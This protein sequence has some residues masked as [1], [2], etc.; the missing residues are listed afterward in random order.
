MAYMILNETF[1]VSQSDEVKSK[2]ATIHQF[3]NINDALQ[4]KRKEW[5]LGF[6]QYIENSKTGSYGV[7]Q[8]NPEQEIIVTYLSAIQAT[9][10][11]QQLIKFKNK[12]QH[13]AA[14]LVSMLLQL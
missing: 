11:L 14:L 6:P 4:E 5:I 13:V 8:I 7:Y 3:L 1:K 12:A 10:I 9:P 2:I